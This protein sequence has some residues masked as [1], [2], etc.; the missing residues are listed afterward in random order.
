MLPCETVNV[1]EHVVVDA[2]GRLRHHYE[3]VVVEV[4]ATAQVVHGFLDELRQIWIILQ[5]LGEL[6]IFDEC[7]ADATVH[8]VTKLIAVVEAL[9][10]GLH[11]VTVACQ[12]DDVA[13]PV[14]FKVEHETLLFA[15][16][17]YTHNRF[18]RYF[19]LQ[20]YNNFPKQQVFRPEKFLLW[21]V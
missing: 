20:R 7:R 4:D 6:N 15:V 18:R 12:T 1:A 16:E 19:M 13:Y 9:A 8:L 14:V 21:M 2:A 11:L 3:V 5:A 17:S 10:E